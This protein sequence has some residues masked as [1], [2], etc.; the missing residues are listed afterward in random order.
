LELGY[1]KFQETTVVMNLVLF[2]QLFIIAI[3][4]EIKPRPT[5]LRSGLFDEG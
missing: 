2:V 5:S 3:F 1:N 4:V